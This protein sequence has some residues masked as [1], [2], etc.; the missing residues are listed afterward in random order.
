MFFNKKKRLAEQ[1]EMEKRNAN[2]QFEEAMVLLEDLIREHLRTL[3]TKEHQLVI[4]DDYG[5]YTFSAFYPEIEYF[6]ENIFKVKI[7]DQG[8]DLSKTPIDFDRFLFY[9]NDIFNKLSAE[10]LDEESSYDD[11]FT[12]LE[13]ELFCANMLSELGWNA[14]ATKGSGDQG[15]DVIAEKEDLKLVLQCKKYSSPVGNKAVQ[16]IYAGQKHELADFAA[17]VTNSTYTKSA[18]QLASTCGVFLLH[19]DELSD[20]DELIVSSCSR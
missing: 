12:P 18:K 17:V 19:F 1:K 3:T 14:R 2:Y 8:I 7:F 13:F 11:L 15:V 10:Y 20:I 4:K 5:N 9:F 16:E 6:F